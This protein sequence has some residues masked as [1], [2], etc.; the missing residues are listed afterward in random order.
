MFEKCIALIT[1]FRSIFSVHYCTVLLKSGQYQRVAS[2]RV[3]YIISFK[4]SRKSFITDDSQRNGL[5]DTY[6]LNYSAMTDTE[7]K[8]SGRTF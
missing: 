1:F 3:I 4:T 6:I 5:S 8:E 7:N 2:F